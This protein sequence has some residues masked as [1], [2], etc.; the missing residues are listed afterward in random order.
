MENPNSVFREMF[1]WFVTKYGYTSA[2]DRATNRNAMGL[3]WHPS[4]GFELLVARLFCGATFAN[5]ARYPILDADIVD[6]GIR[7]L[8]RT[9]LF[10]EEYK[11]WI[12][13]GDDATNSMDFA[14]FRAFWESA[15]NIA[16]FT[17]TPAS[18]HGYGMSATEDDASTTSL[19]DA[20]N[21][22]GVAYAAT[23]ESL[24]SNSA[25]I[26]AMQAQLQMLCNVIGNQP[27]LNM[28]QFHQPCVAGVA[29]GVG[30]GRARDLSRHLTRTANTPNLN[31]HE[32]F[33]NGNHMIPS[34]PQIVTE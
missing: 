4:Q 2:E 10:A 34:H 8:H 20:V 18:Q 27:P 21:N 3:E 14:A 15:V 5:L 11:A 28:I 7:V 33:P 9:G 30:V 25:T 26:N 12:T 29:V 6:I 16:A 13:R 24:R 32:Y 23:Q 19:A 17:A 1:A 31:G 22:F